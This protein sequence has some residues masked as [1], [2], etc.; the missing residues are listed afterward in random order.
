MVFFKLQPRAQCAVIGSPPRYACPRATPQ[1]DSLGI[2]VGG[3]WSLLLCAVWGTLVIIINRAHNE[4]VA[5][6]RG[7]GGRT[8]NIRKQKSVCQCQAHRSPEPSAGKYISSDWQ[9]TVRGCCFSCS[10]AKSSLLVVRFNIV[11]V[12]WTIIVLLCVCL[13][14]RDS[15][16]RIS[17]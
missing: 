14:V 13:L 4:V 17:V 10:S 15:E 12:I 7:G 5:H 1:S 3:C 16:H 11:C 8:V 6:V 2:A 9:F